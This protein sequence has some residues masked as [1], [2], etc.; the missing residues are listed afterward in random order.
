LT[1]EAIDRSEAMTVL[2]AHLTKSALTQ[3]AA[4]LRSRP[5]FERPYGW[6][7]ALT[8]VHELTLWEAEPRLWLIE[9]KPGKEGKQKRVRKC[10]FLL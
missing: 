8:L 2:D 1:P 7:W 6:G 9:S 5:R 10:P 3:E 4:Y